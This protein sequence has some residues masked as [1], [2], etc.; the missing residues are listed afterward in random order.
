MKDLYQY[1]GFSKQAHWQ[2]VQRQQYLLDKWLLLDPILIEWRANHPSMSLKKLYHKI[3]PDFIGINQFIDFCMH[4]G[5]EAIPYKKAPKT[6]V[7]NEKADFPN[8]LIGLVITGINQVWV[9]D[10]TYFKKLNKWFF[11]TFVM[12]LYSRRIIGYNAAL[13]LFATSHLKAL[14]M[15]LS[16]RGIQ[17]F[18]NK[19]T[20]HS[21]RGTQYKSQVYTEALQEAGIQISMGRIV[22]D[23][24]H[25]E[26]VN[27]TIKGEYLIHRNIKSNND[28]YYHLGKDV[29]LYNEERPHL[30]L[31][32]MT[33]IQFERYICN[34][35]LFQRTCM[36]V[37]ALNK[38]VK[39]NYD[40]NLI[41]NPA[42]LKLPF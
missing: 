7:L 17:H 40:S 3:Q 19:L 24:I 9:S 38:K 39:P 42:Q 4:N 6:T 33:P 14:E 16:T 10:T 37:F 8:L 12:D 27:Q 30:A 28:L 11:I 35:P 41:L 36:R 31:N 21:D 32:K 5:F 2:W 1:V 26:R 13:D 18:D 29:N 22:Y 23:N 15:A 25:M 34:I 20:H